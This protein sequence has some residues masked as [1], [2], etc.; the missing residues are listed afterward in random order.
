MKN[1]RVVILG[2]VLFVLVC[3]LC[4]YV[5]SAS[6]DKLTELEELSKENSMSR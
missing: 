2:V 1:K 3:V 4:F 5:H 6:K